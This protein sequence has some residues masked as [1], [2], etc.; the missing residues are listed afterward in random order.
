MVYSD[1]I[2]TL[3]QYIVDKLTDN[4][5]ALG[6]VDIYYG[7]QERIA[8]SPAA[9]VEPG[10]KNRDLQGANRRTENTITIYVIVYHSE[11]R[12]PQSNRKDADALAEA[13]EAVLHLDPTLGGYVRHSYVTNISPGYVNKINGPMRASRLTFE[14]SN[15][16]MLPPSP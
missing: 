14:A 10:P 8:T 2:V 16:T 7:D 11:I 1:S 9:C 5:E 4:A 3:C 6:L 12:S 13:I 15:I